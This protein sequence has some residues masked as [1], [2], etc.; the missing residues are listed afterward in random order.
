MER[1]RRIEEREEPWHSIYQTQANGDRVRE[2]EKLR[3]SRYLKE[4]AEILLEGREEYLNNREYKR[5]ARWRLGSEA[6][7]GR[8]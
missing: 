4:L 1:E 8:Y 2:I 3:E 7:V 6:R 5:I